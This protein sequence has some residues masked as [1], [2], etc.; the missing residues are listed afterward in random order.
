MCQ[1][2]NWIG[3]TAKKSSNIIKKQYLRWNLQG[4]SDGMSIEHV[5]ENSEKG[6]RKAVNYLER[7]GEESSRLFSVA[8]HC[9]RPVFLE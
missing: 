9:W 2:R 7:H 8:M 1:K 6:D 3:N 5:E 4:H